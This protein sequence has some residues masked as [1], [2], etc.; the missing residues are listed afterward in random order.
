MRV[1][2]GGIVGFRVQVNWGVPHDQSND[3]YADKTDTKL[4]W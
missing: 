2:R 1:V 4:V 3:S